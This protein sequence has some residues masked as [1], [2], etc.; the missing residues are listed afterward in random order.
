MGKVA[1]GTCSSRRRRGNEFIDGWVIGITIV[2]GNLH[3]VC[4]VKPIDALG[5]HLMRRKFKD[6]SGGP[7]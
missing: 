2:E 3:N 1:T 6:S 4:A 7:G 5:I